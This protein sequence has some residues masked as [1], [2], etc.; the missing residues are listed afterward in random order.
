MIVKNASNYPTDRVRELL[1]FGAKGVRDAGVEVH[2]KNAPNWT[3]SGRAYYEIP[4]IANVDARAKY[5]ITIKIGGPE[6]FPCLAHHLGVWTMRSYPDGIELE[7]WEDVLVFV[8]AHEFRHIWQAQRTERTGKGGKREHDADKFAIRRL[9]AFREETGRDP[10]E[11]V[12]QANPF[13]NGRE[14]GRKEIIEAME[15]KDKEP[16]DRMNTKDRR[17]A[18]HDRAYE[19]VEVRPFT[20]GDRDAIQAFMNNYTSPEGAV[21]EEAAVE[22]L[23]AASVIPAPVALNGGD[24]INVL[25]E[26]FGCTLETARRHVKEAAK[27]KQYPNGYTPPEWGGSRGGGRPKKEVAGGEA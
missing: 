14:D 15:D 24:V 12:K 17:D 6:R 27:R 1:Q 21:E 18:I 13:N 22:F 11:R 16:Y 4:E 5:L 8:G 3:F 26:D 7:D 20:D 2:V 10:I 9:N 19:L 25:M 23:R